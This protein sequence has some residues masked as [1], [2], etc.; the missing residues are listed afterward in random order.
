MPDLNLDP[1]RDETAWDLATILIDNISSEY[2]K[3]RPPKTASKAKKP[4]KRAGRACCRCRARK[5][6]CDVSI[7]GHP[8]TNCSWEE[9]DCMEAGPRRCNKKYVQYFLFFAAVLIWML[10]DQKT[11]HLE[12]EGKKEAT[13]R[14]PMTARAHHAQ[15]LCCEVTKSLLQAHRLKIARVISCLIIPIRCLKYSLLCLQH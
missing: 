3:H 8:C 13:T 4:I 12:H 2:P 9:V 15:F 11:M 1:S 10:L 5:V 7:Q 6:R 14:R